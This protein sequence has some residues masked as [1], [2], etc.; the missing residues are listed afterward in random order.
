M[1]C[2]PKKNGKLRTVVDCCKR[3]D[4]TVQDVTSFPNQDQIRFDIAWAKFR[5]KI[6]MS[7]AYEQIHIEPYDVEKM[8]F[9]TV[10]GTFK[11]HTM[12]QGDCNTPATF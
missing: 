12:Q 6:D 4:N 9:A 3:N 8:S 7:D 10:Y 1:L 2:I 11:S 5:S